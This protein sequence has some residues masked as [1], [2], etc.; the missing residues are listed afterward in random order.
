MSK[1]D[2]TIDA[3]ELLRTDPDYPYRYGTAREWL[4]EQPDEIEVSLDYIQNLLAF[5]G[6]LSNI[7]ASLMGHSE[8]NTTIKIRSSLDNEIHD[9]FTEVAKAQAN[10]RYLEDQLS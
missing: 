9:L 1:N 2:P 4:E 5:V 10:A 6:H 3:I 7:C 8:G